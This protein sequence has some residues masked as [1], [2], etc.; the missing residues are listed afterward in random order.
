M[1][2]LYEHHKD[3]D[4]KILAT[5][6]LLTSVF[7]GKNQIQFW[8][9]VDKAI[10]GFVKEGVFKKVHTKFRTMDENTHIWSFF[11]PWGK[12]VYEQIKA[13]PLGK[14]GVEFIAIEDLSGQAIAGYIKK[15]SMTKIDPK[16][17]FYQSEAPAKTG[18][19]KD[20]IKVKLAGYLNLTGDQLDSSTLAQLKKPYR[21]AALSLHP[22]RNN[23]DGSKMSD[24]N[25]YWQA[26]APYAM[27]EKVEA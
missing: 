10:F 26:W 17:F 5:D 14:A 19:T 18:P 25:Y 6:I 3:S 23:G 4:G 15:S 11:P 1:Y 16:D 22:D 24:L 12:W 20:E 27:P 9:A 7:P 21:L 2:I 8:N 13:S